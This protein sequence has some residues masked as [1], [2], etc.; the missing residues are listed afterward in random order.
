MSIF[1]IGLLIFLGIHSISIINDSWRNRIVNK[2]GEWPWKGF[3][4]LVSISG[5]IVMVWG[6]EAIRYDSPLLYTP[7]IWLQHLSML[8][9]LPVFPLLIAAYFPGRIKKVTKHPMLLSTKLW[10]VAHLF[11]NGSLVD[12]ILFG[13]FLS[14]AILDRISI[15]H[16]QSRSVPGAPYSN[17]N[18]IIA[19][20]VG[21][22]LYLVFVLWLHGLLIGIPLY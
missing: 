13:S 11:S 3:Y 4:S 18:D 7:P 5:F 9:L 12:V 14:W 10:A 15:T 19:C 2:V 1:L 17:F 8:L 21:L 6:Y 16:R 22:G 20:V